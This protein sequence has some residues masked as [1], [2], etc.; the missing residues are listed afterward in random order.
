[1]CS[2]AEEKRFKARQAETEVLDGQKGP[3]KG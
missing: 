3:G 1:M 2:R